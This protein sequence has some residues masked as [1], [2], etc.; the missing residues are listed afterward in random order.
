MDSIILLQIRER[1]FIRWMREDDQ[2]KDTPTLV[3]FHSVLM[4]STFSSTPPCLRKSLSF[5]D[6]LLLTQMANN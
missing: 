2:N 1:V 6:F 4:A 3:T 5:R